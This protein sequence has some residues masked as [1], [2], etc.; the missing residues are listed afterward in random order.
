MKEALDGTATQVQVNAALAELNSAIY[1]FATN[2]SANHHPRRAR[3]NGASA[4][5]AATGTLT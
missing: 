4:R 2:G 1:V 3:G 5:F